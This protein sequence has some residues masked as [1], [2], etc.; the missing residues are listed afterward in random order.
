M[1]HN[2]PE[3]MK[4][5]MESLDDIRNDI[6]IHIDARSKA[7]DS[8]DI[9]KWVMNAHVEVFSEIKCLWGDFSLVQCELFLL[10]K[11][12][13]THHQYYHLISGVDFPLKSTDYIYDFFSSNAGKE[14][15]FFSS[16]FMTDKQKR[17]YNKYHFLQPLCGKGNILLINNIANKIEK[18]SLLVQISIRINRKK[19]FRRIYKGSQW[20][21]ITENFANYVLSQEHWIYKDFKYTF[22]SDE[23]LM[24]TLVMNSHYR[25]NLYIKTFDNSMEQNLRYIVF[26]NG[27]PKVL[28]MK[29]F[30]ALKSTSCIFGRKFTSENA[31]VVNCIMS[32][33]VLQ[34]ENYAKKKTQ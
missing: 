18:I 7:F 24:P 16:E 9:K 15:I 12:T 28:S 27:V 2:D 21:S 5:L 22:A 34:G 3:M 14:F 32:E 25:N 19:H 8:V 13:R 23:M 6:F 11:A 17:W 10:K 20:F 4:L 33:I 30:K 29:D 1:A 26:S 31:D